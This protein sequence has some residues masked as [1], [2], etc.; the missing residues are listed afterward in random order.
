MPLVKAPN[1]NM[2][3]LFLDVNLQALVNGTM[4]DFTGKKI[5]NV[6]FYRQNLG[7]GITSIDVEINTSLQPIVEISFKDLYG[8]AVFGAG[9][10]GINTDKSLDYS[11]LFN[12]PPPKFIFSFKGYLGREVNWLLNLKKTSI[13]YNSSDGSYDLKC[14]FV[15]NQ[16][17]FF[18]DM[19]FLYLL[20]VKRLKKNR[21]G[22][23]TNTGAVISDSDITIF[24]LIKIGKQVDISTQETTKEFD[25]LLNQ[26]GAIKS[27]YAGALINSK[28]VSFNTPITGAV[29]DVKINGF[30]SIFIS[31]PILTGAQPATDEEIKSL[32]NDVE[33]LNNLNTILLLNTKFNNISI[34]DSK[35]VGL[36][37]NQIKTALNDPAS[38][39]SKNIAQ[40]KQKVLSQINNN[41]TLVEQAIKAKIFKS[42]QK[43]LE[44]ITI[45]QIFSK[46][47]GDSAYILGRI[48]EAGI[49]GYKDDTADSS[50]RDNNIKKQLIGKNFPL[51]TNEKGEE[52]PATKVNTGI[53]FKVEGNE[54]AF[55]REFIQAI[56]EGIAN[57][58]LA[59]DANAAINDNKLTNRINNLEILK[60]NPYKPFYSNIAENVLIRSGIAGFVSRTSD[61]NQPGNYANKG[62]IDNDSVNEIIALADLDTNNITDN[63]ISQISDE[64]ILQ[65][66]RF[67]TFFTK[68]FSSDGKNVL[69]AAGKNY[70]NLTGLN[71]KVQVYPSD[72]IDSIIVDKLSDGTNISYF[73][74]RVILETGA[75][76]NLS[77]LNQDSL[78][79][80]SKQ[81]STSLNIPLPTILSGAIP[82]V[83]TTTLREVLKPFFKSQANSKVGT[84][85]N[86]EDNQ[87]SILDEPS[88]SLMNFPTL[89]SN[90][91][92]NNGLPYFFPNP[93][94]SSANP[95]N[96]EY[97]FVMFEGEDVIN[98]GNKTNAKSDSEDANSD[99]DIRDSK[100][101][102]ANNGLSEPTGIIKLD[103]FSD[104]HG[105]LGR[106]KTINEYIE[107]GKVLDYSK[108]KNLP[109]EFYKDS[110]YDLSKLLWLSPIGDPTN[111]GNKKFTYPDVSGNSIAV[112]MSEVSPNKLAYTVFSHQV[113]ESALG[114]DS[115]LVFGPFL[116]GN[117]GRNQR[118]YLTRMCKNILDKLTSSED[119]KSQIIGNILGKA[120]EQENL[121]YK[122]LHTMYHQWETIASLDP[123]IKDGVVKTDV[124]AVQ[125]N[126][127]G[128]ADRLAEEYG[129]TASH[130]LKTGNGGSTEVENLG[131]GSSS[132]FVYEFPLQSIGA[133]NG[134]G[135]NIDV[136]VRNSIISIEPLY[137]PNANTTVLNVIQ[138]VCTKN[139]FIFIPI[140]GDANYN[141]IADIFQPFS[142][143]SKLKNFFHVLFA[144]TPETRSKLSNDSEENLTH[145]VDGNLGFKTDAIE[146]SF[147]AI[148]N[149]IV[150]SLSVSTEDNKPTAESIVNLQ[151]LVDNENQNKVVT[152]N[153]SM[154]SVMEGRSYKASCEILGNA[155]VYP[156]QYFFLNSLPLFGG[157]YQIMKVKH[158]IKPNDMTT[159]L[160]GIRMRFSPTGGFGAVPPV[161]L[162]SLK[163]L[164]NVITPNVSS[165]I[166]SIFPILPTNTIGNASTSQLDNITNVSFA[167]GTANN[168][169]SDTELNTVI[170]AMR[171]KG[172]VVY[173]DGKLNLVGARTYP[174]NPPDVFNDV[175]Y[176]F[177]YNKSVLQGLKYNVT[178]KP[179]LTSLTNAAKKGSR[180]VAEGQYIDTWILGKFNKDLQDH[181][182]LIQVRGV[183]TYDDDDLD[184]I[185]DLK[186]FKTNQSGGFQIH[187]IW[188]RLHNTARLVNGW[189]AG[190]TVFP[191]NTEHQQFIALC[192]QSQ[193][194]NNQKNFTY[195]IMKST[196]LV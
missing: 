188:T 116:Y 10:V 167:A 26:L 6:G 60:D 185:I 88:T 16:W 136:D 104:N 33:S 5:F 48:L 91:V 66:K 153:C 62:F 190:C 165:F 94:K 180:I 76:T 122:Q 169:V 14:S 103:A 70:I 137:K 43:K 181:K 19:P 83:K 170:R 108:L 28:I 168:A 121:I 54:L 160:E 119:K 79:F 141:N 127:I 21:K 37:I 179:G 112:T 151:R 36:T 132:V 146:F 130:T 166:P 61:P 101:N 154:L 174:L 64:D 52:V 39:T 156:M 7:F 178:T 109:T 81:N 80:L 25:G 75:N 18:A 51:W 67:C 63:L 105:E 173:Q 3:D 65:L 20:A 30:D 187:T 138:Q 2:K 186:N 49:K 96:D 40:A 113:K 133:G 78:S 189:S 86:A 42:S 149:Q 172:Y 118:V 164:Q 176:V 45:S 69:N 17:G 57:N 150:R 74:Y 148:D 1:F 87:L 184:N 29:G 175:F 85:N 142:T 117:R 22:G 34:V 111:L 44:Q 82:S 139:N 140:P 12:W 68:F 13:N 4:Y 41:T 71:P 89:T 95:R 27:N 135:S 59:D 192:E 72:T 157:L 129:G 120:G 31:R 147:G 163:N 35:F 8:N 90:K 97:F 110:N 158:S 162:D 9:K 145:H 115:N 73:D 23:T 134:T 131:G 102:P 98:L 128:L 183:N 99:K 56:T 93:A 126:D 84:G 106:V 114:D 152:T 11:V 55:V 15:P 77:Q 171:L 159:S 144:P 47:A 32:T 194:Q 53:D 24:D 195:T 92:V 196:D 191:N 50:A 161:T 46:L 107:S 177:W 193:S 123:A 100:L 38:D 143:S 155:Q 124:A 58:I 182:A 125:L